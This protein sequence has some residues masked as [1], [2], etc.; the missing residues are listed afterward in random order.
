MVLVRVNGQG[1]DAFLDRRGEIVVMLSL[2]EAGLIPPVF[3]E[4]NNGLCYGYIPGRPFSVEDMQDEDMMQR[5]AVSVARLHAVPI[6]GSRQDSQPQVWTKINQFM[7]HVSGEY[8]DPQ[9]TQRFQEIFGSLNVLKDEVRALQLELPSDSPLVFC[10]ND[11]L[12]GNLI[13]NDVNGKVSMV[14]FE[15]GGA[16]CA[17]YDIGNHFCEFAGITEPVDYSRY[18]GKDV[19]YKW[20]KFYLE[21][22]AKINGQDP[23]SVCDGDIE[24]L[25]REVNKY[26]LVRSGVHSSV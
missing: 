19:Q 12:C 17:A 6:P 26:A 22:T 20:L 21:E 8:A 11:L 18:P 10:H 1:T 7:R 2:H 4:V 23:G 9:K 16:N 24:N 13:Y 15:Y 25:Y 5:T 3:L 14:D